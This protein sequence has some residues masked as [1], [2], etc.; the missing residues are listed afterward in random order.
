MRVA[1]EQ[2]GVALQESEPAVQ[3][4]CEALQR[5]AA[6]LASKGTDDVP[7]RQLDAL[8]AELGRTVIGLQYHDRLTQHL[9]HVQAYLTTCAAE[10]EKGESVLPENP[11]EHLARVLPV[12]AGRRTGQAAAGGD[13]ELF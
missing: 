11:R 1:S 5:L 12:C 6:M 7:A 2:V 9:Q 10:V 8:R 4:L 3:A 13:I